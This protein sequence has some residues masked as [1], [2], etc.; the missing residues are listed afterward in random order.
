MEARRKRSLLSLLLMGVLGV[1]CAKAF[2][3]NPQLFAGKSS[4]PADSTDY[5]WTFAGLVLTA[6][7]D[8]TFVRRALRPKWGE[9]TFGLIFGVLNYF[10][11]TLF[12]YDSWAF[13]GVFQSWPSVVLK[14]LCQGFTMTAALTLIGSWL[15]VKADPPARIDAPGWA[16]K[17]HALYEKHTV[18]FVMGVLA[19]CWLP[20]L[21]LFYP[22]IIISDMAWMFEQL[23]GIQPM[24][25]W[26]SVLITWVF[27]GLVLLG[28]ALG[29]DA[30][31][32]LLYVLLQTAAISY[33]MART[34][35]LLRKLGISRKWQTGA[36]VFFA[37][38]PIWPMYAVTIWKDTIHT[39]LLLV[40]LIETIEW[41]RGLSRFGKGRWTA[42]GALALVICLW[43]NN[44]LYVVVPS[45]LVFGLLLAKG[46]QK[47]LLAA[48]TA[49]VLAVAFLFNHALI[50]ALGIIDDTASGMYS[51]CFQQ[52]A[53]VVRY[54]A[55]ELTEKEKAEIDRVL[56][57]SAIGNLYEPWIS[58][59]VKYTFRQLGQGADVEREALSRYRETWL[60]MLPKYP[61]EY[62]MAFMAGNRGY[63]TF[64][65][66]Y[67]GTTYSQQA[68]MRFVPASFSIEGEGQ[69]NAP[70]PAALDGV[71]KLVYNVL[72]RLRTIPILQ[73]LFVCPVY[74]W[75]LV[76]A[77]IVLMN[78][79]R[80]REL[81]LF[82][83]V[84][85]SLAVCMVSPVDDYFRYFLPII[86]MCAPLLACA[87]VENA[88]KTG[89][90]TP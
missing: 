29:S 16:R 56:D 60:E 69:L 71:R 64:T 43:R 83:P 37:F 82:M 3:I 35:R 86:A 47:G 20:Y 30:I 61:V 53:R 17:L 24:T 21:V 90:K 2:V 25:T 39:A 6:L 42:Y 54:H 41:S 18:L 44:G 4:I 23:V 38:F 40:W 79:R 75:T 65:P 33:A 70:Q 68:G 55:D 15:R 63:Y 28:R 74:T 72:E 36:L 9:W 13:I 62:L 77:A 48:V 51:V 11:T 87:H 26:H 66:Q 49:G 19:L 85:M 10:G 14:C 7:F 88:E 78:R 5:V 1:L 22:G 58:D 84:L 34:M 52:T 73:M 12:A 67:I 46:R 8:E 27:G 31:G 50:P 80:W 57:L 89:E 81:A 59:P 76:A 32:C 45:L